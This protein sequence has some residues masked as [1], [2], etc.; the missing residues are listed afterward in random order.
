MLRTERL[1]SVRASP[2]VPHSV[3]LMVLLSN[4]LK[5]GC[6]SHFNASLSLSLPPLSL[7][8]TIRENSRGHAHGL[9]RRK[10]VNSA[11][12]HATVEDTPPFL[13]H[14]LHRL[15]HGY[16]APQVKAPCTVSQVSHLSPSQVCL[17]HS[18]SALAPQLDLTPSQM[19]VSSDW[20]V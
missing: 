11:S 16:W 7:S 4:A 5:D 12:W 3:V 18:Q 15:P 1:L 19:Q 10:L 14:R 8:R 20:L 13:P 17:S 6:L 9:W 2:F